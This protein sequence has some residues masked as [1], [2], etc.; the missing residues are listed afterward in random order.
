[1]K[2]AANAVGPTGFRHFIRRPIDQIRLA[3]KYKRTANEYLERVTVRFMYVRP[4]D[5]WL[6]CFNYSLLQMQLSAEEQPRRLQPSILLG[7][8]FT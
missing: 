8:R 2:R 5:V 4:G 1:M 6:I 7:A 3:K